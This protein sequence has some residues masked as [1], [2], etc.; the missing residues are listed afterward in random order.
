MRTLVLLRHGQI[1]WNETDLFTGWTDVDLT[2]QAREAGARLAAAGYTF[3]RCFTS[4]FKRAVKSL[5]ALLDEMDLLWLP[6]EKRT[7]KKYPNSKR[8]PVCRWFTNSTNFC[9]ARVATFSKEESKNP[10]FRNRKGS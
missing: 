4:V 2:E 5:H 3:D 8:R 1:F 9:N 7:T 6:E 10:Q